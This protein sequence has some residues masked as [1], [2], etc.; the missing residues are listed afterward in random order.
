MTDILFHSEEILGKKRVSWADYARGI[1]VI[2][3]VNKHLLMGLGGAHISLNSWVVAGNDVFFNFRMPMFFILSGIFIGKALVK[4]SAFQIISGRLDTVMYPY[5][6]WS[7]IQI[8]L[9]I[10]LRNYTNAKKSVQDYTYILYR[11]HMIEQFWYLYALFLVTALYVLIKYYL[12]PSVWAQLILGIILYFLSSFLKPDVSQ[13]KVDDSLLHD[14]LYF[15][16][17]FA[18]GDAVS[19]LVLKKDNFERIASL[20]NLFYIIIPFVLSQAWWL[21][22][23]NPFILVFGCIV[24]L[25][26]MFLYLI[27]FLL[28]RYRLLPW[29][30]VIGN[31]SLYIYVMHILAISATRILLI[32]FLH[33]QNFYVL[34]IVCE[35]TG[36]ILPIVFYNLTMQHGLWFLYTFVRPVQTN[37]AVIPSNTKQPDPSRTVRL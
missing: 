28:D 8:S 36:V 1:A 6:I 20:R 2:L 15:Y 29:L 18:I 32:K 37:V 14:V 10:L 23:R 5:L 34:M 26:C 19:G 31:Y 27:S 12:K 7:F 21:Y 25:G 4:K 33:Q 13:F 24:L 16:I 30:R 17:F 3:V 9:Q 35:L 11:P 22:H